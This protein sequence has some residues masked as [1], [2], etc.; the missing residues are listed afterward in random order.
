MNNNFNFTKVETNQTFNF[1]KEYGVTGGIVSFNLN[2]PEH[3]GQAVD[4]D[5][6]LVMENRDG[7]T[8]TIPGKKYGWFSKTFLGKVDTPDTHRQVGGFKDT[9]YFRKL[10]GRGVIHHGDD[11][12]G[13]WADGEF[14]EVDLDNI[15]PYVNTLTFAV[16]SF[17]G[18]KFS[19]LDY[20][21]IKVFTG[22]PNAPQRALMEH[23][24]K[25]FSRSTQTVVLAQ[26][27][28]NSAGEWELTTLNDQSPNTR[29]EGVSQLCYRAGQP[30][31]VN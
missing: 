5:A 11:T 26:M 3:R 16:L 4:L 2:W 24:L 10:H 27:K 18:H 14:I 6:F 15:P 19:D 17:S 29:V 8:E 25:S 22:K 7:T 12:T 1:S 13:A 9:I 30:A 31:T 21:S 20:A 23:C 28:K